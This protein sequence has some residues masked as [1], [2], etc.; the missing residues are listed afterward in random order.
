MFVDRI[1]ASVIFSAGT[2]CGEE[3]LPHVRLLPIQR[4][5]VFKSLF[6]FLSSIVMSAAAFPLLTDATR[7]PS[8]RSCGFLLRCMPVPVR[9]HLRPS[10]HNR[11]PLDVRWSLTQIN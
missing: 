1:L 4:F 3:L 11:F 7:R 9:L 10:K 6:S 2:V 8:S 5:D